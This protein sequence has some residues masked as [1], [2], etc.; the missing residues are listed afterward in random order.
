LVQSSYPLMSGKASFLG[1]AGQHV[2]LT[3]ASG[4]IGVSAA[5]LMLEEGANVTLHFNTQKDSLQP[6]L[7]AF[8]DRTLALRADVRNEQEVAELLT[9]SRQKFGTPDVL[10]LNHGVFP[11]QDVSI[12]DMS[13]DQWHN[14]IEVNLTGC[15]LFAREF[16]RQL[17][18]GCGGKKDAAGIV[19]VGSTSGIFGEAGHVDYSCSKSGLMYGFMRSLKNE[20]A[21]VVPRGRVN[22]V[23][24]GWVLTPMAKEAMENKE[25]VT[26]V[27]QTIPM[28]KVANPEDV[29]NAIAYLASDKASGHVSGTIVEVTGGMEG[30]LLYQ[31]HEVQSKEPAEAKHLCF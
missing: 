21:R 3:G 9:A 31:P 19:L 24:P 26:R 10:V 12:L 25:V 8:P 2:L 15:F 29:A 22:T 13:L 20:I 28:R 14:T 4:G 7:S 27:L 11:A 16:L 30:R 1:L 18:D 5:K 6:L 17:K 23:A